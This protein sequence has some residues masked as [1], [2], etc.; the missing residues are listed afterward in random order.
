MLLVW[1]VVIRLSHE[2]AG[3]VVLLLGLI[4]FHTPL[5]LIKVSMIKVLCV[6]QRKQG[7]MLLPIEMG[8]L[9]F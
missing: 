5:V 8:S 6:G 3:V 4:I 7:L 1:V 9:I 2:E